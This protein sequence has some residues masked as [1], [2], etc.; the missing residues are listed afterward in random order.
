MVLGVFQ[1]GLA[2][3]LFDKGAKLTSPVSASLIGLLEAILNPVWVFLFYGEKVGKFALLGAAVILAAVVLALAL[4]ASVFAFGGQ[5]Y[6]YATG[7]SVEVATVDDGQNVA[8]IA[9]ETAEPV[10]E[11]DGRVYVVLD[12]AE[13]DITGKFSYEEP[14]IYTGTGENGWR[15]ALVV[16]GTL[17]ELGWA[18]FFWD[19]AGTPFAGGD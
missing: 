11:R 1:V 18:E 16:G 17:E 19:E 9:R 15:H 3:V 10:V 8:V 2:Y 12:G 13:S 6:H 14:Y 4:S 7:A 5:I